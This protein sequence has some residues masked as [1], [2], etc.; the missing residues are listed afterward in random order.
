MK[1]LLLILVAFHFSITYLSAQINW[2]QTNGPFGGLSHVIAPGDSGLIFAIYNEAG[3]DS[4]L[5]TLYRSNNYGETWTRNDLSGT[6]LYNIEV[7][8]SGYVFAFFEH[9]ILRSTDNGDSWNEVFATDGRAPT[10]MVNSTQGKLFA[11]GDDLYMSLDNGATWSLR[12]TSYSRLIAINS[13]GQLL[14]VNEPGLYMSNDDGDT[15]TLI[16]DL[17][18]IGSGIESMAINAADEILLG[19]SWDGLYKVS[20]DGTEW[21]QLTNMYDISEIEI[22]ASGNI[23]INTYISRLWASYDGGITWVYQNEGLSTLT[24]PDIESDEEG[25]VYLSTEEG[26]FR[27]DDDGY[28]WHPANTGVRLA[29]VTSVISDPNGILYAAVRAGVFTSS[30]NGENWERI[31]FIDFESTVESIITDLE[32]NLYVIQS[33]TRY[34]KGDINDS[35]NFY[36]CNRL[37]RTSD[38]GQTWIEL[39]NAGAIGNIDFTTDGHLYV[40]SSL[41][42]MRSTDNGSTWEQ[43]YDSRIV[44][45][46]IDTSDI[47]Y[48]ISDNLYRSEDLGETWDSISLE[49]GNYLDLQTNTSGSLYSHSYIYDETASTHIL[50]VSHDMGQTWTTVSS[51][52]TSVIFN[53]FIGKFDYV[54]LATSTGLYRSTNLG[55]DFIHI[56]EELP[57]REVR[58]VT[59]DPNGNLLA[60]ARERSLWKS[61]TYVNTSYIPASNLSLSAY[62]NPASG[63]VTVQYNGTLP[64]EITIFNNLGKAIRHVK[65]EQTLTKVNISGLVPGIYFLKITDRNIVRKMVVTRLHPER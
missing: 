51:Q 32:G 49:P 47:I 38:Q 41:G 52:D 45:V 18:F 20:A 42:L 10:T 26:V 53:L 31:Y 54:Y 50:K 2:E 11:G 1:K 43:I 5:F 46:A 30:D 24:I 4:T 44:K 58:D 8:D 6:T 60:A 22:T 28:T 27:S 3:I 61:S 17:G 63:L 65:I 59:E 14:K 25:Y 37:F 36:Y 40:A 34:D 35:C 64:S 7:S 57:V 9:S 19:S 29:N 21:V 16:T 62:P 48:F 15:W 55:Q 56:S 12:D 39:F 23:Y 13:Q 33:V